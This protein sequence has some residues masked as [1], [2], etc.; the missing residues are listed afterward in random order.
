MALIEEFTE[1]F[2]ENIIREGKDK[3]YQFLINSDFFTA[4]A[5]TRYHNAFSGGL[6]AHS[7]NVYNCLKDFLS[8]EFVQTNYNINIDDDGIALIGLMHD[9]CKVNTYKP[10]TRN[11]KDEKGIWQKVPT[12]EYDDKLPYGHGE[13]SVYILSGFVRLTREEAF[14]IRFHMGF[15]GTEDKYMVGN[16]M[17]QFPLALALSVADMESAFVLEGKDKV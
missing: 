13:K 6:V 4:P 16:A 10:S 14:A 15:S 1:I 3:L 7:I 5:S 11:V 12:Y 17:E 2:N 9:I 8:R